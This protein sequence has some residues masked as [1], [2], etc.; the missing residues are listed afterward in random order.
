MKATLENKAA[1]AR[2]CDVMV[3]LTQELIRTKSGSETSKDEIMDRVFG[4][5]ENSLAAQ[6]IREL[7]TFM[8]TEDFLM[9]EV[10]F[11]L[12]E[13]KVKD[14]EPPVK[15]VLR[16]ED[17]P[18]V[19]VRPT[20]K[21]F[22]AHAKLMEKSRLP[23]ILEEWEEGE[24]K[25]ILEYRKENRTPAVN[26]PIEALK[27]SSKD[28][29]IER[30][31]G[32]AEENYLEQPERRQTK[33]RPAQRPAQLKEQRAEP[34]L[35]LPAVRKSARPGTKMGTRSAAAAATSMSPKRKLEDQ[36][37]KESPKRSRTLGPESQA[38]SGSQIPSTSKGI[39]GSQIP[40]TSKGI[41]HSS[42]KKSPKG[43]PKKSPKKSN[44]TEDF[45]QK[46]L[47]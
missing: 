42:P 21:N 13:L 46:A 30:V 3:N 45:S 8:P 18:H 10:V 37:A 6:E 41:T 31:R 38:R 28:E 7:T 36:D 16:A 4:P 2:V 35:A 22:K 44:M 12:N 25:S 26:K 40:S 32:L 24:V 1:M 29:D 47:V 34:D 33:K 5:K 14:V 19:A 15:P 27:L 11:R 23:S 9:E 17:I 20:G 43:S 39:T